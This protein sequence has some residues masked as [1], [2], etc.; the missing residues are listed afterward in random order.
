M[1]RST[2]AT[3]EDILRTAARIFFRRGYARTSLEDIAAEVGLGKG[4]VAFQFKT[5]E[6][7]LLEV[8]AHNLNDADDKLLRPAFTNNKRPLDQLKAFLRLTCE[9]QKRHV[10]DLGCFFGRMSL[11][12]ADISELVRLQLK[13]AFDHYI[14]RISI[15]VAQAQREGELRHDVEPRELSYFILAQ[16]EG[17]MVLMKTY[18][19]VKQ[20]ERSFERLITLLEFL[21]PKGVSAPRQNV[22]MTR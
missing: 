7:L 5:K 20:M 11:E 3:R 22:R 17:A 9:Y 2:T 6:N 10:N 4:S 1:A 19:D 16:M 14:S 8:I 21:S 15:A 13:H 12:L 18:R